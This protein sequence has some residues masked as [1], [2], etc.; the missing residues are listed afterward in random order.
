MS[1]ARAKGTGFENHVRDTYLRPIWPMAD[2]APLR[3]VLDAGDFDGLPFILEAK[4]RNAWRIG[5]WIRTTAGKAAR[6]DVPWVVI[7][8]GDKRTAGLDDDYVIMPA[9]QFFEIMEEVG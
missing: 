2:R 5:D 9:A 1:K 3:G 6:D 7:F 4:K 8:A